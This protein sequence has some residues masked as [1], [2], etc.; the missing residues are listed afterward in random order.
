[1]ELR[2]HVLSEWRVIYVTKFSD[3]VYVL[4]AFQKKTRETRQ[5]DVALARQRYHEIGGH[6]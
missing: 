4:H 2:I 5:E 1:M 6:P 3:A